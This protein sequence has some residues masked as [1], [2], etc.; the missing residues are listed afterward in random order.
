MQAVVITWVMASSLPVSRGSGHAFGQAR[1]NKS[2]NWGAP[3]QL[4]VLHLS[5][6]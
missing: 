5:F 2:P 4:S 1:L 6:R 3:V